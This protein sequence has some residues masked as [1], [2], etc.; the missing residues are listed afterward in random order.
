MA[1]QTTAYR[2]SGHETFPCRYA[3]LSKAVKALEH[4]LKIFAD[5]DDAMVELGVGKNMM[6]AI[7]FWVQAAGI[8]AC[9]GSPVGGKAMPR[10]FWRTGVAS[11]LAQHYEERGHPIQSFDCRYDGPQHRNVKA[12]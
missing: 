4:R 12:A 3:W 10:R 8:S 11:D 6:R 7:R 2:F 5:E 9:A 1:S